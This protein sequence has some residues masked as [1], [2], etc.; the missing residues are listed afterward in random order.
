MNNSVSLNALLQDIDPKAIRPMDLAFAQFIQELDSQCEALPVAAYLLSQT[1]GKGNVCLDFNKHPSLSAAQL[2]DLLMG[3]SKSP[4]VCILSE[5]QKMQDHIKLPLVLHGKRLYLQ[6]Y[7][8][9][10]MSLHQSML[11]KMKP[12]P[13]PEQ[14]QAQI[15]KSLFPLNNSDTDWQAVAA[16]VAANKQFSVITGG[17]GTGKTTTVI[18][19]LAILIHQYQTHFKRQPIIKLAAPTGKAAMRLTESINGAK[20]DLSVSESIKQHIP[21]QASTLHRLLSRNR[22]GEFKYNHHNPLHLD[23]LIVDEASMV[24]LPLMS[25]LM[26]ALPKHGQIILLG[27]KDQLAS[28]EAG[29]VLADICDSETQH[30]YSGQN[31]TLIK[32]LSG[33]ELTQTELEP[34]GALLRDH[35]CQLR[36]SYRFH[37]DSGIGFLARAANSGDFF[38]WQKTAQ[39]GFSDLNLINLTQDE[40]DQFITLAGREYRPFL[41]LIDNTGTSDELALAIYSAFSQFQ[42]LCALREGALGVTGLNESIEQALAQNQLID[43][44]SQWYLGRPVMI[45]END[46][47]L[48]LY[49]GDIGIILPQA[50]VSGVVRAKVAFI[51]S[52]GAVRWIQ[53]SR[54][55]KHETVFAMTVHK[56]QGSEF[57]HCALVL[58]DY[59]ASV[60]TK[61]LIYTGITRAKKQLTLIGRESVIKSGLK[62][63]VQRFSGLRDRLWLQDDPSP[64][65]SKPTEETGA[66]PEQISLF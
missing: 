26:S 42:V 6:R 30:G 5:Q 38:E 9:Y 61:E 4:I 55:P 34:E 17:P 2:H 29:S 24:D 65:V 18:R 20:N 11:E 45:M 50:D 63:K 16:C 7:W 64:V 23:V 57:N 15:I 52:D 54:L 3:I 43:V 44:N 53:P 47:G 22:R 28:V 48:N 27:D 56:S 19:L 59:H 46:Y 13:W 33:Q 58:P 8:L 12:M 36:K 1:L 60:V 62:S 21:G 66:Q 35:I 32:S 31:A 51:G 25:K 39:K 41:Q 10:E 14:G 37:D 49:N 40:F